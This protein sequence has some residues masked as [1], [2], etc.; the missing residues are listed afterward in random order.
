MSRTSV[1]RVEVA[2]DVCGQS[3]QHDTYIQGV[4]VL[5]EGWKTKEVPSGGSDHYSEFYTRAI[6]LCPMCVEKY[7]E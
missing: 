5:R 1:Y 6:D 3:Y 7:R 4:A 2:C